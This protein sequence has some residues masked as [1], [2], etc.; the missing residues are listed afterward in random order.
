VLAAFIIR[1]MTETSVN[2]YQTT[3]SNNPED[4]HLDASRRQNLKSHRLMVFENRVFRRIFGPKRDEVTGGLRK[5][6]NKE[7]HRLY[8]SPNI[9]MIKSRKVRWA[10]HVARMGEMRNAYMLVRKTEGRRLFGRPRRRG[11][12]N[13]KMDRGEIVLRVWTLLHEV[14]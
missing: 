7:L 5:L 6:H 8:S 10:G 3:W 13:T 9:R 14:T 4:S 11:E 12:N 2:L 1:E